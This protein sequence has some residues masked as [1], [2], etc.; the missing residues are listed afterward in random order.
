MLVVVGQPVKWH[1]TPGPTLAVAAARQE[2]RAR[3]TTK[4]CAADAKDRGHGPRIAGR[5]SGGAQGDAVSK[6]D[7]SVLLRTKALLD[8]ADIGKLRLRWDGSA[9]GNGLPESK[10]PHSRV[11][12]QDALQS[13]SRRRP[14]QAPFRTAGRRA[15]PTRPVF[16]AGLEGERKEELL[17]E[18]PSV[19]RRETA[20]RAVAGAHLRVRLAGRLRLGRRRGGGRMSRTTAA[21]SRRSTTPSHRTAVPP[22]APRRGSARQPCNCG[23]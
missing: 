13:D 17:F 3:V 20:A 2:R 6:A 19:S 1:A 21:S 12:A 11:A 22:A 23:S 10:R 7:D 15:A 4:V 8:A 9:C 14:P 18:P 16:D 5:G